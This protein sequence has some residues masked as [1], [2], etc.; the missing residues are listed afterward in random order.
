MG[1]HLVVAASRGYEPGLTA[2]LNSFNLYHDP[3]KIQ[4]H[5]LTLEMPDLVLPG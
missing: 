5:V 1:W 3:G 4:V 2:F